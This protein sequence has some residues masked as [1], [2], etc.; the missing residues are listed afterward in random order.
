MAPQE[1][2]IQ[3][4]WNLRAIIIS[5]GILAKLRDKHDVSRAEVEQCFQ[6]RCGMFLRD[7]REDHRTDPPSLWFIAETNKGRLL[8]VVCMFVDG[9]IHIKSVFE[10]NDDEIRLY[11]AQG[12]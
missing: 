6:N 3:W 5:D 1:S 11:E 7:N 8:K 4:G 9:N 12:K 2:Y 10:P